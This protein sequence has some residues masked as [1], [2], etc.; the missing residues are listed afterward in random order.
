MGL[1]KWL[2]SDTDSGRCMDDRQYSTERGT[3]LIDTHEPAA[4]TPT[5]S[6]L[7]HREEEKE[8]AQNMKSEEISR[9]K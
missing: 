9:I 6:N 7:F 2:G 3:V 5:R 1:V 4:P 8:D